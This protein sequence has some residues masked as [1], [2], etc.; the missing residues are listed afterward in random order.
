MTLNQWFLFFI[1]IQVIHFLA[2]WKLYVKTGKK[3]WQ[4]AVPIYNAIVLMQIINRPKWWVILLFIPIINL[5]MFPIIWVETIRSF[6]K[7]SNKDT[8]LVILT[9][10]LYIFYINY[11]ADVKYI[12]NRSLTPRT[13]AGEW[14]S[15]I[16][17][18][19]IAATLV[20]TYVMQP[21]TIPTSSLEKSLLIGDF[22]FVSKFHYGARVPMTTIA[23]PMVHDTLPLLKVKS[24]LKKPQLPYFRFPAMQKIKQNDI[25]VFSWPVD[26]VEQ[27]FKKTTRRIRKPIDKKSNYVKRCVGIAGDSLEIRDGFVYINGKKNNLPDRA[28]LQFYH[29]LEMK[30]PITSKF[31]DKSGISEFTRVYR[32][33]VKIWDD[34][35]MV[36]H[37]AKLE[38][39]N[40]SY[41]RE[42]KRDSIN[43]LVV[44]GITEKEAEKLKISPLSDKLKVN[45]TDENASL[46]RKK[47][48]V[49]NLE[50]MIL[51]K[52]A[53]EKVFANLGNKDNYGPIYIPEEGKTVALTLET[54][55]F[56]KQVIVEYE[57]NT[58]EVNGNEI[59]INGQVAKDYT[60]QQNYYWM[61]GDNRHN[62]EDSRYWGFV[63]FDHVVGKPVFIWMSWN[64]NGK[65]LGKI[66]WERVFTTVGGNGKPTSYLYPFLGLMAILYGVNVYRNKKKQA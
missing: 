8:A 36:S 13:S 10:G 5:L 53:Y 46:I 39:K 12:E 43:V 60:F 16:A 44:G 49:V 2:T 27:F 63:P 37:L 54:L 3:A 52:G 17:F 59:L 19:I 34:P 14:V 28:K 66:R 7:N 20:H 22:L 31:L 11:V 35:R 45:M 15:S 38:S 1:A 29:F 48:S 51:P 64:T 23:A 61:M 50:K 21:Y 41:L 62:S 24:Y 25:V 40:K 6:G 26:T 56:Y 4:A 47:T 9:L 55:P 18:A 30:K 33:K 58:L 65:G 57:K 42:Y 32:F